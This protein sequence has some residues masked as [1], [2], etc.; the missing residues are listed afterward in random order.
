ML[1]PATITRATLAT[2]EVDW[3]V[4]KIWVLDHFQFN[5]GL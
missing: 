2:T 5:F 3:T 4:K 1:E